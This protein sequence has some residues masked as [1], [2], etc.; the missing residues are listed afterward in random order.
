[1]GYFV[2]SWAC[3]PKTLIVSA[4]TRSLRSKHDGSSCPPFL[5]LALENAAFHGAHPIQTSAGSFRFGSRKLHHPCP[6]LGFVVD[7]PVVFGGGA[8]QNRAAQAGKTG[9]DFGIRKD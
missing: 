1:A 5:G 3:A 9:L 6:L 4:A 7:E 8:E 2:S